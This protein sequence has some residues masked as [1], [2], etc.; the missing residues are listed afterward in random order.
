MLQMFLSTC[1]LLGL[2]AGTALAQPPESQDPIKLTLHDWTASVDHHPHHGQCAAGNGLQRRIQR[3]GLSG[4]I[5]VVW[6]PATSTWPWEMWETTGKEAMEKSLATGK[7]ED[8][9]R[10]RHVRQGGVVVPDLHEGKMPR[11]AGLEGLER[12][13]G[14][15]FHA[16]NLSQGPANLGGPV[17]W[18]GFDDERVEALGLEYEVVHAGTDAALFAELTSAYQRKAPHPFVGVHAPL[19][20]H[21]V[22]GRMGKISEIHGRMLQRSQMGQQSGTWPTT[23]ANPKAGSRRL[24]GSVSRTNGRPPTRLS[25]PSRST[26]R[27]WGQLIARVDLDGEKLENVIADWMKKNRRHLGKMDPVISI[28]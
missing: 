1:L 12:L 6:N 23:A 5:R 13:C 26:T 16:G 7:T 18:G 8:M 19:G 15:V 17:T 9:W 4:P 27:P 14:S 28:R 20:A 25:R 3:S 24:P 21:Q 22:Q 11:P 2:F 10:N